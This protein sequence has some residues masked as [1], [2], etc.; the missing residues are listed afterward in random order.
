M[1]ASKNRVKGQLA[2]PYIPNVYY[3]KKD[4]KQHGPVRFP[5]ELLGAQGL[6]SLYTFCAITNE[7]GTISW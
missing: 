6:I 2:S 1:E 7:I 4:W 3:F 5:I